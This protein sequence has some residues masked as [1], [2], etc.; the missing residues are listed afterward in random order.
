MMKKVFLIAF[1]LLFSCVN[2]AQEFEF[3]FQQIIGELDDGDRYTPEMGSYDG[4]EIPLYKGESARFMLYTENFT[5]RLLLASPD[6]KIFRQIEGK[7]YDLTKLAVEVPESG[8]WYLYVTATLEDMGAYYLQNAIGPDSSFNLPNNAGFCTKIKFVLAHA[9]ASFQLL[10]GDRGKLVDFDGVRR[11][12]LDKED[13]SFHSVIYEGTN[14]AD[15][16]KSLNNFNNK[17]K[18]CIPETWNY[19]ENEP[20]TIGDYLVKD[21]VYSGKDSL[22]NNLQV[23]LRLYELKN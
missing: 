2:Y 19:K 8:N 15:A 4:Y 5:P 18:G 6:G 14:I 12:Y 20:A 1:V 21:F 9:R 22:E 7:K 16:E 11:R 23:I 17:I 10:G 13:G 3:D